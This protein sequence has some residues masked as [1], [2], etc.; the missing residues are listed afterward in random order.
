[1]EQ[2]LSSSATEAAQPCA[3]F[4]MLC[5]RSFSGKWRAQEPSG[6]EP[7][8]GRQSRVWPMVTTWETEQGPAV[9]TTWPLPWIGVV[10]TQEQALRD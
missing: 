1:M 7:E 3:E 4:L 8:S 6:W 9:V 10:S 2:V 5:T